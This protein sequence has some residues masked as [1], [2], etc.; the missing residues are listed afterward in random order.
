MK[1]AFKNYLHE[2]AKV[3]HVFLVVGQGKGTSTQHFIFSFLKSSEM[4]QQN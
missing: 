2:L 4:K 3:Q 1:T